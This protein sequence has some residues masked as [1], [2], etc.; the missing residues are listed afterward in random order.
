MNSTEDDL[1]N[2][3]NAAYSNTHG[4]RRLLQDFYAT[5]QTEGQGNTNAATNGKTQY[6]A[7]VTVVDFSTHG[8]GAT[9]RTFHV[10]NNG[11]NGFTTTGSGA[12]PNASK[13]VMFV[14]QDEASSIYTDSTFTT[15]E[16]TSQYDTD[17]AAFRTT[18]N[19]FSSNTT[20]YRSNIFR[21]ATGNTGEYSSFDNFIVAVRAGSGS[22]SGTNGLSDKQTFVGYTD[23]VVPNNDQNVT[24]GYYKNL[25]KTAMENLGYSFS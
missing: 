18:L 9:E 17:I 5:G 3:K 11:G 16:K 24:T 1:N 8:S 15:G 12:F 23:D 4:L 19:S 2:M 7:K 6:E 20:F 13:V 22:Y 25:I 10:L 14:F 21:V